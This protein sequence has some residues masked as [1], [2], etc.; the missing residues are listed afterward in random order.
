MQRTASSQ[1]P[2][3]CIIVIS[4]RKVKELVIQRRA[5]SYVICHKPPSTDPS[6]HVEVDFSK[7]AIPVT[8]SAAPYRLGDMVIQVQDDALPRQ[9][10]CHSVEYLRFSSQCSPFTPQKKEKREGTDLQP[11]SIGSELL[12]LL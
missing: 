1:M 3:S 4:Q 8:I 9:L 11:S 12:V 7:P 10:P 5:S 6:I 2:V